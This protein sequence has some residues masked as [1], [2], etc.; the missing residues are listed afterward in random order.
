MPQPFIGQP[1]AWGGDAPGFAEET[2]TGELTGAAAIGAGAEDTLDLGGVAAEEASAGAA[3]VVDETGVL[4]TLA[5]DGTAMDVAAAETTGTMDALGLVGDGG[6][7]IDAEETTGATETLGFI[8][9]AAEER[10]AV[11]TAGITED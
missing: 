9:G 10:V 2:G 6:A 11:D 8:N 5:L 7:I 3:S 4:E 1:F